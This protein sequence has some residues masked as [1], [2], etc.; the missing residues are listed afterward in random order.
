MFG[1][2]HEGAVEGT[3][4]D[5]Y[6]QESIFVLGVEEWWWLLME[7]K[8]TKK[9]KHDV[10]SKLPALWHNALEWYAHT[11]PSTKRLNKEFNFL[12]YAH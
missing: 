6:C 1:Y 5:D 11:T 10:C 2:G 7:I 4:E 3:A 9:H 12:R 8:C